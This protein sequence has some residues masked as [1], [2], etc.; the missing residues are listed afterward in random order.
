M[1][2]A[3]NGLVARDDGGL[4]SVA[5]VQEQVSRGFAGETWTGLGISSSVA[6]R[7]PRTAVGYGHPGDLGLADF[8]GLAVRPNDALARYTLQGDINLSGSVDVTDFN[9]WNAHRFTSVAGWWRGDL[10]FDRAVDVADFN[11]WNANKFTVLDAR[12]RHRSGQRQLG[13]LGRSGLNCTACDWIKRRRT[14]RP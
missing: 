6:A 8:L 3:D 12:S 5:Y 10:N 14:H 7:T 2:L 13:S 9:L 11:S 1:D 4:G